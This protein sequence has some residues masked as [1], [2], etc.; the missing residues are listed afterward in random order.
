[1]PTEKR[2]IKKKGNPLDILKKQNNVLISC[3]VIIRGGSF[4]E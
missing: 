4:Y 3:K 1:M 2:G